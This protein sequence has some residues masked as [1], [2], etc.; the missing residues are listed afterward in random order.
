MIDAEIVHNC[1]CVAD[2]HR[3][4]IGLDMNKPLVAQVYISMLYYQL[5]NIEN[6]YKQLN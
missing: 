5:V 6:N 2:L 1:K 4:L 3:V